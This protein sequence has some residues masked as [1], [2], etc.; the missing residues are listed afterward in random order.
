[1]RITLPLRAGR[2]Q[3][4][5]ESLLTLARQ[6]RIAHVIALRQILLQAIRL[7]ETQ[8]SFVTAFR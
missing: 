6:N 7:A 1:M 5:T 8:S 4:M 3:P 2:G